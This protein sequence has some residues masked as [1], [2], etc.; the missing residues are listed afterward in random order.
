MVCYGGGGGEGRG[1]ERGEERGRGGVSWTPS[2]HSTTPVPLHA[3][4]VFIQC[5]QT[6][7]LRISINLFPLVF[8][9]LSVLPT[10]ISTV[11]GTVHHWAK[12]CNDVSTIIQVYYYDGDFKCFTGQDTRHLVFATISLLLSVMIILFPIFILVIS[13]K[14]FQVYNYTQLL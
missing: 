3:P 10:E 7:H 2:T 13:F 5:L 11:E 9:N 12:H 6:A 1:E 14:R 8:W 4:I